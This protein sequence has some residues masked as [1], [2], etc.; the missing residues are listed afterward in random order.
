[1][2]KQITWRYYTDNVTALEHKD[3]EVELQIL[4]V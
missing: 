1:M 3:L 2:K 4:E